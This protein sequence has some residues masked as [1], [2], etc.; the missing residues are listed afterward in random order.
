MKVSSPVARKLI[1]RARKEDNVEA[2]SQLAC[3]ARRLLAK[4]AL[5]I[6]RELLARDEDAGD[7]H[8]PLLL[9]WAME[10]KCATDADAVLELFADK[11]LWDRPIVRQHIA[12]RLMRRFA[13][14]GSRKELLQCARLLD[15]APGQEDVKRLMT[16]FE[17]A[18]QGRSLSG[19]PD[20][21]L[22]VM[23]RVGGGSPALKVRQ[24]DEKATDDAL[25]LIADEKA[26][27]K[28]RLQFV[29]VFGE[30]R[31][32]RAVPILLTLV[33]KSK[34]DALRQAALAS[35]QSYPDEKIGAE[36][37]RLYTSLPEDV[38]SVA[39]TL[40]ASRKTW[41][42]ELLKAVDAGK[43]ERGLVPETALRKVLLH[44]DKGLA[45]L[46][47]KLWGEVQGA[48]TEEMK[49]RIVELS[50]V[51]QSGS[52]N[53]YPGRKLYVENCGKCHTLFG[54]GG[55][56]GPDLTPFQRGDLERLL[57]NVVNPSA[58]IREGFETFVIETK[59]GRLLTG[60]LADQDNR[61][62]VLRGVDGQS[63][64]IARDEIEEMR[65]GDRS[66]MPEDTLK[67]LSEQQLRDLFAYLRS[68]QP[69]Q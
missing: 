14:A 8:V 64:I 32:P 50:K 34:D 37:T 52:G 9:W 21:L 55:Q 29:Q 17:A 60:F 23:I 59:N 10:S 49:R 45:E 39:Q 48:T 1:E 22:K 40:L 67:G 30:V 31:Q 4:D 20:E 35:L 28:Q 53:P 61:V 44:G 25:K 68:S 63:L 13:Q 24:G 12:E 36:V 43:I 19:L 58:E 38:R 33:E 62:V 7:I 66:V 18:F 27:R 11:K 69:V 65:K 6:V 42:L 26:D 16:G 47:K 46:V 3:S 51:I 15:M 56:V 2:R 41:A 5:P 57:V 54:Q